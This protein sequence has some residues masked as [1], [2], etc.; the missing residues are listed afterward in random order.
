M[1]I[2]QITTDSRE[3]YRDYASAEPAFGTA[4]EA[5]LQGFAQ[6]PEVEVHVVSCLRQP[7]ASPNK[8]A[9]NIFYHSLVVPGLGWMKS[10]YFGCIH[11]VRRK[12]KEINPDIVHGQGTERDC[13][14]AAVHS[15]YPNVVTIHGNMR[16]IQRLGF[17]GHKVFGAFASWLEG[18]TLSRTNGVFCNSVHTQQLV[19]TQANTTWVVP[20]AIR[21]RF[22]NN[23]KES[24]CSNPP[25][26]LSVGLV[27]PLKRQLEI[28]QTV[29]R[30]KREGHM[31]KI[32][33]AGG[34]SENTE[35][36]K[37]FIQELRAAEHEGVAEHVGFLNVDDLIVLM[38]RCSGLIHYPAEEAFGL[39]VAEAMARGMKFFGANV[40][41]IRDIVTNIP[42]AEVYDRM[43]DLQTGVARWLN[44]GYP[45]CPDAAEAVRHRYDPLIIARRHVA[46]YHD[47]LAI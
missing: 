16:E 6:L 8:I 17:H 15:G 42:G 2:V 31:L 18:Y 38:D 5:L 1:R 39:V 47:V 12:L 9:D 33:F 13:A 45:R 19:Q 41:G 14:I 28:L 37:H 4:P 46:I 10:G 23:S 29:R 30:L 27:Y 36:G 7:V 11:A 43:D 25:L 3:H 34:L 22:F 26:L 24:P 32:I 40:G 21:S 35:Y 20:N 44:A